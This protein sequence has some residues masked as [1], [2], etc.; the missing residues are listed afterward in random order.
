V[1]KTTSFVV[2]SDTT[3]YRFIVSKNLGSV[4]NKHTPFGA[5]VSTLRL[6]ELCEASFTNSSRIWDGDHGEPRVQTPE[7]GS[8]SFCLLFFP[9]TYLNVRPVQ[10]RQYVG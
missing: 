10:L 2:P 7:G 5:V 9:L 8:I 3:S 4:N 1:W 6:L